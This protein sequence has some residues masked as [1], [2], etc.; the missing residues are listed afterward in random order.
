MCGGVVTAP[1]DLV[2]T[3]LQSSLFKTAAVEGKVVVRT[4]VKGLLWNFADVANILK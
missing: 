1:F 3:R 4:G 2:K